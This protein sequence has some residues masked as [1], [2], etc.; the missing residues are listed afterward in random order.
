[1]VLSVERIKDKASDRRF[2]RS[3]CGESRMVFA[4]KLMVLIAAL[5]LPIVGNAAEAPAHPRLLASPDELES[6]RASASTELGEKLTRRIEALSRYDLPQREKL[7]EVGYQAAGLAGLAWLRDDKKLAGEVFDIVERRLIGFPMEGR[8][9]LMERAGR[10]TGAVIAWDFAYNLWPEEKRKKLAEQLLIKANELVEPLEEKEGKPDELTLVAWTAAGLCGLAFADEPGM[11]PEAEKFITKAD[12]IVETYL[13]QQMSAA[14]VSHHGEGLKQVALASG[15]MPYMHAWRRANGKWPAY[16]GQVANALSVIAMQTVPQCGIFRFA[17]PGGALDRSGLVSMGWDICPEEL[18]PSLEWLYA[19]AIPPG[20]YD[21]TRP[22]QGFFMLKNPVERLEA[23]RTSDFD[24][25]DLP[26]SRL[27]QDTDG[28]LY[29]FRNNWNTQRGIAAAVNLYTGPGGT[30]LRYAGDFRL[31]GLG[32]RWATVWGMHANIWGPQQARNR[33]TAGFYADNIDLKVKS[34]TVEHTVAGEDTFILSFLRSG[35]VKLKKKTSK[36]EKDKPQPAPVSGAYS[37]RRSVGID[38]SG[39]SGADALLVIVDRIDGPDDAA[40]SWAMHTEAILLKYQQA[41][42]EIKAEEQRRMAALDQQVQAGELTYGDAQERRGAIA[43]ETDAAR[44]N[45]GR[46][47]Q[48]EDDIY[49]V[50]PDADADAGT[51]RLRLLTDNPESRL[52]AAI[53]PPYW[54]SI[55][56]QDIKYSIAV[57]TLN[58][59]AHP[60]IKTSGTGSDTV[61]TIGKRKVSFS[62]DDVLFFE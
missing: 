27:L 23:T 8:L 6:L 52:H 60:E 35:E 2:G 33:N 16:R 42:A 26:L 50:M 46:N 38:Y 13:K 55:F 3:L 1:M 4:K 24:A 59:G 34:V 5:L 37:I 30:D 48:L 45:A 18:Q 47:L 44:K 36:K 12:N 39:K 19:V 7:K 9:S 61:L 58:A 11:R 20:H 31:F 15:I 25:G 22:V 54:L 56:S 17:P 40:Q 32:G 21:V 28:G 49:F 53:N 62:G 10:L 41:L 43:D 29:V 14:G 51:L 57:L